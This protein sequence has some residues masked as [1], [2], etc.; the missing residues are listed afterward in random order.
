[1]R[2]A[3]AFPTV[4]PLPS[5]SHLIYL[6]I[7]GE[8]KTLFFLCP[9]QERDYECLLNS[10]PNSLPRLCPTSHEASLALLTSQPSAPTSEPSVSG[11]PALVLAQSAYSDVCPVASSGMQTP[12]MWATS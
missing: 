11:Q 1:M 8:R 9:Q 10:N 4:T 2:S 6:S 3:H 5:T 12:C 7:D